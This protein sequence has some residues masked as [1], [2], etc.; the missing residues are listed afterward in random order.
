MGRVFSHCSEVPRGVRTGGEGAFQQALG[1]EAVFPECGTQG[2]RLAG[3]CL[4]TLTGSFTFQLP[5]EDARPGQPGTCTRADPR[6]PHLP[7]DS[8]QELGG[9]FLPEGT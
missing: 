9:P 5:S 2:H 3:C 8:H 1:R 7:A 6:R 4:P